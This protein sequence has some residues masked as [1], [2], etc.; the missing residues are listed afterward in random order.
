MTMMSDGGIAAAEVVDGRLDLFLNSN[1]AALDEGR[2]RI[3]QHFEPEKLSPAVVNRIELILEEVLSNVIRH[4]LGGRAD[5]LIHVVAGASPA[6][7]D[8]VFEDEGSP[9]NPLTAPP[10]DPF[11]S[12]ETAKIGGLGVHLVKKLAASVQ[13]QRMAPGDSSRCVGERQFRPLN[14][15]MILVAK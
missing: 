13:Y 7:V 4:G 8:L 5:Q 9:F 6:A 15:L 10:P 1:W 2:L 11:E 3:L 12:L 14:R